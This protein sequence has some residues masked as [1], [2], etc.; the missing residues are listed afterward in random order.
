[1]GLEF[2]ET[3]RGKNFFEYQLPQLIK[4]LHSVAEGLKKP[5]QEVK[6]TD[7]KPIS[8]ELKSRLEA[9][10]SDDKKKVAFATALYNQIDSDA[11]PYRKVGFYMAKA[12]LEQNVDDLLI[13]ICG[14]SVESLLNI[15]ES[16]ISVDEGGKNDQ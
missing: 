9:V 7:S 14:W 3:V 10:M 2:H 15:A 13:A 8:D 12:I 11:E 4:E 5:E 6:P 1:M 16:T